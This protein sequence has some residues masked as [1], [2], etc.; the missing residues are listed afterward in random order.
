MKKITALLLALVLVMGLAAC[1][2]SSDPAP[3]EDPLKVFTEALTLTDPSGAT[4]KTSL[5][6]TGYG[7]TLKGEYEVAYNEDGTATVTY[8]YDQLTE[9]TEDTPANA[10]PTYKKSGTATVAADG[11]V[12]GDVS[13][14]V[15]SVAGVKLKIDTSKMTYTVSAG[16]LSA[17]VKAADTAAILGASIAYDVNLTVS[18]TSNGAV[19]AI[20]ISYTG[21]QG[22][23]EIVCLY[24]Y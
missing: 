22:P 14:Q 4:V 7:I 3:K 15:A 5:E 23:V 12:S 18:L 1:G 9:F 16:M 17:T 8:E 10:E 20:T 24:N 21:A 13:A 2:G 19:S 11:T 6:A